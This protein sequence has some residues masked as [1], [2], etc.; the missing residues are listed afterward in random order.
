M[1]LLKG[2]S[3]TIFLLLYALTLIVVAATTP[4]SPSEAYLFFQSKTTP[5]VLLMHWGS[6]VLSN[7]LGMRLFFLMLGFTNAYLFY[8]LTADFF[9][10]EKER[11]LALYFYLMLPGVIVSTV[12]A[13]D[14]V[15]IACLV[16][17]FIYFHMF[18]KPIFSLFPLFLLTFV[19]WSALYF[20][21]IIVLYGLFQKK[22]EVFLSAMAAFLFYVIFGVTIPEPT[23]GNYFFEMLGIYAT[24]FSPLLFVYLF[25]ALYKTLLRGEKTL[26]W[27]ISFGTLIISF[28]LSLQ[29]RIKITDFSAYLMP[30]IMVAVHSYLGSLKVRLKRF[31]RA[32]RVSFGVIVFSLVFS[33]VAMLLH[34]PVYRIFG[35]KY[36]PIVASVYKP[37]DRVIKL[38][39]SGK[40]CIQDPGQKVLY[41]MRYYG[42]N[43]CF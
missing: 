29:E 43:R 33:S 39:S 14:A 34:Q 41:Q 1:P 12:L 2:S 19:H 6:F 7:E 26:L 16:L 40:K 15:I 22:R 24:I 11:L 27:Y 5:T 38:K 23:S 17:L 18:E 9:T 35:S 20:Y 8:R 32:Y 3:Q 25:Y 21:I 4:I 10:K 30:G 31:Q 28:V 36:Y 42:L 13:N 37:Y